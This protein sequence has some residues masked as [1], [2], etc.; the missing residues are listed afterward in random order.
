MKFWS[1]PNNYTQDNEDECYEI[2][3]DCSKSACTGLNISSKNEFHASD[4]LKFI[5]YH[6]KWLLFSM[7]QKKYQM[8]TIFHVPKKISNDYAW[9]KA[10]N[11]TR[12]HGGYHPKKSND[13][14]NFLKA[15][16]INWLCIFSISM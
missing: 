9:D 14:N 1:S 6:I 8:T 4:K 2:L 12:I 5:I 7:Y 11:S 15:L 10:F 3:F 16:N 13:P